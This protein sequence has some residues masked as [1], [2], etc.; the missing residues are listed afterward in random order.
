M[1]VTELYLQLSH[2][3]CN[4]CNPFTQPFGHPAQVLLQQFEVGF[5][6]VLQHHCSQV[7]DAGGHCTG[8]K[9]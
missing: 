4:Q 5:D 3:H 1:N 7:I 6:Q 9:F 8:I 2:I